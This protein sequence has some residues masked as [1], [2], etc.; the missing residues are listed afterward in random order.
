MM[1]SLPV[2][3]T[4]RSTVRPGI[5]SCSLKDFR[6]GFER[7]SPFSLPLTCSGALRTS[8]VSWQMV[9][10]IAADLPLLLHLG[11]ETGVHG[12]MVMSDFGA[13]PRWEMHLPHL[14]VTCLSAQ[15]SSQRRDGG[16]TGE[17]ASGQA[18]FQWLCLSS[19]TFLYLGTWVYLQKLP[20]PPPTAGGLAEW[21]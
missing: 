13:R 16:A 9:S 3:L 18:I 12:A 14:Q 5:V 19:L 7:L 2:G 6:D 8:S 1:M 15:V 10:R 20:V 4:P 11:L 17:L 21:S